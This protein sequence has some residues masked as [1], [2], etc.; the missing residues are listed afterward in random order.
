MNSSS[1]ELVTKA[2]PK[3]SFANNRT[4]LQLD[5][6]FIRT[7]FDF[8]QPTTDSLKITFSMLNGCRTQYAVCEE[9]RNRCLT[10]CFAIA[11]C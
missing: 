11:L 8:F 6:I 1:Y 3:E 2:C 10:I 9:S 4:R 7:T 5:K